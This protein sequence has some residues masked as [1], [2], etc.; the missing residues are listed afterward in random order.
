MYV[1][2][3]AGITSRL[4]TLCQGLLLNFT[5]GQGMFTGQRKIFVRC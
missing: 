3:F 5:C 2:L 1:L 4:L